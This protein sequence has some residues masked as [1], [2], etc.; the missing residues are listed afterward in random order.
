MENIHSFVQLLELLDRP[1]FLVENGTVTQ[2]NRAARQKMITTGDPITKYL[3]QDLQAYADFHGGC[4]YLHICVEGIPCQTSLTE[5]DGLQLFVMEED[6]EPQLRALSLAAQQLRTPMNNIFLTAEQMD[7][8]QFASQITQSLNQMH[9]VLCNMADA[10]QYY[11]QHAP[12]WES[13]DLNSFF[14]ETV[15]K[16]ATLVQA[17]GTQLNYTALPQ[18]AVGM[19]DRQMLERAIL[20]LISNAVKFSGKGKSVDAKLVKKGNMLYFTIQDNGDGI[21]SDIQ[22][23]LFSRYLRTP[24]I[25]DS[26]HG[27][28]LG[29]SLVRSAAATHGGTVLI[30][31]PEGGGTRVTITLRLNREGSDLLRSPALFPV[32]DYAGGHDH[33]LLELSDVLPSDIY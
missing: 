19:A 25:E 12:H 4:L 21:P 2:V 33:A 20:N 3:D 5:L 13:T 6:T 32:I 16:A 27:I 17:A 15:E 24:G 10:V 29:L 30:D 23:S 22:R 28:G 1:A 18:E 8:R 26:R 9:R 7:D 11:N 14:S 31:H